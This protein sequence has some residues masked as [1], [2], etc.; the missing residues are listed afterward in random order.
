MKKIVYLVTFV[1]ILLCFTFS[2]SGCDMIDGLL[3]KDSDS[4][5]GETSGG[6]HS[7]DNTSVLTPS[8]GLKLMYID[9]EYGYAVLGIGSCTDAVVVIPSTYNELP[10]TT[11]LG[12]AFSDC[13]GITEIYIPRTVIS[14]DSISFSS[15][16]LSKIVVEEDNRFYKSIDGNLYSED[17]ATLIRYAAGKAETSF[18]I[19]EGVVTIGA[20]AFGEVSRLT[21]IKIPDSVTAIDNNAFFSC[22]ELGSIIIPD[23]VVSVGTRAFSDCSALSEVILGKSVV[24]VG[25]HAFC[26]CMKLRSIVIPENMTAIGDSAFSRCIKLVE[27]INKSSLDIRRGET[28][29]GSVAYYAIE[30]H[31]GDSKIVRMGDYL[32]YLSNPSY[33]IGYEGSDTALDLP[34]SFN[35]NRYTI[36]DYA[37]CDLDSLKSVNISNGVERIGNLAFAECDGLTG[38]D[39]PNSVAR[40]GESAF[41]GC[42]NLASI[43]IPDNFTRIGK[44]AFSGCRGLKSITI[45]EKVTEIGESAFSWCT[46]LTDINIPNGVTSIGECA[47]RECSSLVDI[48]IPDSVTEIGESAFLSCIALESI[49]IPD[50]VE[51]ISRFAFEGCFSL[52]DVVIPESVTKIGEGAFSR[53]SLKNITIPESVTEICRAAFS[54]CGNLTSLTV[55]DKVTVIGDSAFEGCDNLADIT[56]GSGLTVINESVFQDCYKLMSIVIPEGITEI[57]DRAFSGCY[58]L[59]EVINRSSLDI[60]RGYTTHGSVANNAIEVHD[61]ESKIIDIDGYLFY[62][63]YLVGYAGS[64]TELTLPDDYN[65][66]PYSVYDYAFYNYDNITGVYIPNGI[67]IGDYAFAR[68][69]NLKT[70]A[71]NSNSIQEYEFSGCDNLESII[72]GADPDRIDINAFAYCEKLTSVYYCGTADE[73]SEIRIEFGNENLTAAT[74]YFFS[75]SKPADEGNYW[76]YDAEGN[77]V[78]W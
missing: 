51:E 52:T 5:D 11:I 40:I 64:D 39:I 24:A 76:H 33:L 43:T 50:S 15:E 54:G 30:V 22:T 14:L 53:C 35:E 56:I 37:F 36:Y 45:P 74:L 34:E 68:C 29:F 13:S 21:D 47:F 48:I 61:G 59:V 77:A 26:D 16:N 12:G 3:N 31:N 19:P 27:V 17:G 41:S 57:K 65:G 72:I 46:A 55:P 20:Y 38:M 32:F 75:E 18:V 1:V 62:S 60:Q 66:R 10:V 69:Y 42:D 73:W 49:V 8:A 67:Y 9:D 6:G 63:R 28:S 58:K 2:L 25:S 23:N 78:A 4:S 71:V 44:A 70:V 7:K